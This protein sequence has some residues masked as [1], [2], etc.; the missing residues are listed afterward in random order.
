M[1]GSVNILMFAKCIELMGTEEQI[2]KFLKKSVNYEIVGCYA[3]TEIGHG[4]DVRSLETTATY[5]EKT[6]EF[7][8]NMP[9]ISAAKFWPG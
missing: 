6:Q 9:S 2:E 1:P 7:L 8:I 5:D 3:Q 4:S